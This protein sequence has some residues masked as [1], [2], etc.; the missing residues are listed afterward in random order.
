MLLSLSKIIDCPG[1]SIP[2]EISL[3]FSEFDFG[4]CRP[5]SEPV[6]ASGV[7]R[8]TAGVLLLKGSVSTTLH[9]VCDRCARTF[10]RAVSYP[11]DV[12]LVPELK[13]EEDENPWAFQLEGDS[14]DLEDIV[15]TV[16]VL[17]MDSK[18]LCSDDCRGL[19]CQCGANLNDGPCGCQPEPDPRLAVLRQ[20]L[21]ERKS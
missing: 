5:A 17:N 10:E 4:S 6:K 11:M 9:G 14:V 3:N 13:N 8:N 21:K 1:G 15:R 19:C 16:F 12:V 20:L 2:F 7:I 18:L